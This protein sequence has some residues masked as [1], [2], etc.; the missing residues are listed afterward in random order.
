MAFAVP[1]SGLSKWSKPVNLLNNQLISTKMRSAWHGKCHAL[2]D[3]VKC[4]AMQ[5]SQEMLF[6]SL[7]K[8]LSFPS[9]TTEEE[10]RDCSRI[11]CTRIAK[12]VCGND[13]RTYQNECMMKMQACVQNRPE[14][15]VVSK[16]KCGSPVVPA[17]P[18]DTGGVV[19]QDPD[20]D[21]TVLLQKREAQLLPPQPYFVGPGKAESTFVSFF[22]SWE[23]TPF[24][25]KSDWSGTHTEKGK[26]TH[27]INHFEAWSCNLITVSSVAKN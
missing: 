11:R 26:S 3:L 15:A 22:F 27:G 25:G 9:L 8:C 2:P 16:G 6:F 5:S 20:R 19:I 17:V 23:I 18:T 10:A 13:G 21:A 14:L 12:P 4:M 7:K 24:R 1:C